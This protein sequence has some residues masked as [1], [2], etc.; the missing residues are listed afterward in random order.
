[1]A[2]PQPRRCAGFD[3]L[4]INRVQ[5][6]W[7][8]AAGPTRVRAGDTAATQAL[9]ASA[10]CRPGG[11]VDRP[12]WSPGT[13]PGG[14]Q[15]SSPPSQ[16]QG[17]HSPCQAGL[18]ELGRGG[19]LPAILTRSLVGERS[20]AGR[21][22]LVWKRTTFGAPN[23]PRHCREDAGSDKSSGAAEEALHIQATLQR[24]RENASA[25]APGLPGGD[26]RH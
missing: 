9:S 6:V 14:A 24:I 25:L 13:L 2:Q 15:E 4:L 12:S 5:A 23:Y 7:F 10:P 3:S 1:M 21:V 17:D 22:S 8:S 19:F 20:R 11:T 16:M 26:Q 18:P